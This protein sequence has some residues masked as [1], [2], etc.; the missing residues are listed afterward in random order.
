VLFP[1][2]ENYII[3]IIII[4]IIIVII[5]IAFYLPK[6]LQANCQITASKAAYSKLFSRALV[7]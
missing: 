3:I 5:F 2:N 1:N 6:Q 7:S 4:I